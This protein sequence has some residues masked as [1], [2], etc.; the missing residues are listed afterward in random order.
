MPIGSGGSLTLAGRTGSSHD[1][2]PFFVSSKLSNAFSKLLDL[3][4]LTA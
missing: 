3:N 4:T 2:A 1:A